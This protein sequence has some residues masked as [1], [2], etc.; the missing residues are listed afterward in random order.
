M[1]SGGLRAMRDARHFLLQLTR[2]ALSIAFLFLVAVATAGISSPLFIAILRSAGFDIA[3]I[4]ALF[5]A[6]RLF[7]IASANLIAVYAAIFSLFVEEV[8]G[9]VDPALLSIGFCL[10]IFAFVAGRWL[11][12]DQVRPPGQHATLHWCAVT[13]LWSPNSRVIM[14]V[15][16]VIAPI[17]S[18]IVTFCVRVH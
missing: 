7:S 16:F 6:S 10:P 1:E 18:G 17:V 3:V 13:F 11:R 15:M 2:V 14:G 9:G 5:P 8:F 4:Q 12:R